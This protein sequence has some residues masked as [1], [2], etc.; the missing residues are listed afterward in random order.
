VPPSAGATPFTSSLVPVAIPAS[1]IRQ[2][3]SSSS[4]FGN[5]STILCPP[6]PD[7]PGNSWFGADG[8]TSVISINT[9]TFNSVSGIRLGNTFQP[10]H[11]TTGFRFVAF[12]LSLLPLVKSSP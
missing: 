3:S 6:G 4:P 8:T 5:I 11:G 10:D 2:P 12:S 9:L 1:A 7:G